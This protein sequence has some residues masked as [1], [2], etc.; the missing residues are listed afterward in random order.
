MMDT[1]RLKKAVYRQQTGK[2]FDCGWFY[3]AI[4][5]TLHWDGDWFLLCPHCKGEAQI[6]DMLGRV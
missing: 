5:L 3:P 6:Q 2:C 1:E 4:V